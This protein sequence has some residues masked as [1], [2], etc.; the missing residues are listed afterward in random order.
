MQLT[1]S[2][3]KENFYQVDIAFRLNV[4]PEDLLSRV[5]IGPFFEHHRNTQID[6]EQDVLKAGAS[7]DINFGD[8]SKQSWIPVL[9]GKANYMADG[10][11]N[12]D[13]FQGNVIV[14]AL[15]RG[16]KLDPK[17]FWVPNIAVRLAGFEFTYEP[18]FGLEYQFTDK[19]GAEPSD[20]SVVR[21]LGQ[22]KGVLHPFAVQLKKRLALSAGFDRRILVSDSQNL[23]DNSTLFKAAAEIILFGTGSSKRR[24]GVSLTFVKGQDPSNGFQN[25]EFTNIAFTL[26]L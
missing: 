19:S 8:L 11:K 13:S 21:F 12:S 16:K 9:M 2:K 3:E 14:T 20:G 23:E 7:L 18:S 1:F 6:K 4:V 10:V 22:I 17:Y 25:Q 24:A 15:F 5:E 26:K